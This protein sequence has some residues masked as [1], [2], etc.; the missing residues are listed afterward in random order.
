M[1][2]HA[3]NTNTEE[4]KV[5]LGYIV[6]F[7][8]SWAM[9]KDPTPKLERK[10]GGKEGKEV[11][12]RKESAKSIRRLEMMKLLVKSLA[13]TKKNLSSNPITTKT[14]CSG[15]HLKS[16]HERWRQEDQ[17]VGGQPRIHKTK[18]LGTNHPSHRFQTSES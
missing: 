9:Q 5:S 6:T 15:E 4:P 10:E 17:E 12:E 11:R 13:S 18:H 8:I 16:Q 1:L 2:V 14:V 3:Y 7:G